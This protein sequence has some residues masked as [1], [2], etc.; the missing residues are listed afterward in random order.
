MQQKRLQTRNEEI[1]LQQKERIL[2]I[3]VFRRSAIYK[4]FQRATQAQD[5]NMAHE[6]STSK[7]EELKV[8]IDAAYPNFSERLHDL[9]PSLSDKEIKVC[10]LAKADITPSGIAEILSIT[11]QAVTNIR[12]RIHQ[13]EQKTGG[14]FTNFD[15]FIESL[16]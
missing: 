5:I 16:T 15:H 9:C 7:W 12:T 2:R 11:R 6:K 4:I 1:A 8:G 3:A 13:K 10:L 14:D